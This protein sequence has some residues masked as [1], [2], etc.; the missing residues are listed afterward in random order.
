L[1]VSI[2][3]AKGVR[4]YNVWDLEF[5]GDSLKILNLLAYPNP[6]RNGNFY[7]TFNLTK[8]AEVSI[9]IYTPTG[10]IVD[11]MKRTLKPGFNSVE[12]STVYRLA[13]GIYVAVVEARSG[14]E[15]VKAFTRFVIMR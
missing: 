3:S 10:L 2:T 1:G 6:Y 15:K 14:K 9:K 12:I 11:E 13:N 5:S 7:I 8:K 4:G